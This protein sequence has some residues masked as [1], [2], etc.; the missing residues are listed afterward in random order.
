MWS[1]LG[2]PAAATGP[3][4]GG[5]LVEA[6]WR[7]VFLINVPLC[8]LVVVVVL[9]R[10]PESSDD[11][12]ARPLDLPGALVGVLAL[13]ALTYGLVAAGEQGASAP[14]V[15]SCAAGALGLVAFVLVERAQAPR[16]C[17]PASS[18]SGR[19]AQRTW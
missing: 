1:A 18:P 19:S 14:V 10:V 4:V 11:E 8:A 2:G 13:G 3:F 5:L 9:R 7:L 17:R 16:C 12:A 6:S 15:V